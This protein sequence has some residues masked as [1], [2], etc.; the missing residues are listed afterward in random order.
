MPWLQRPLYLPLLDLLFGFGVLVADGV[1]RLGRL[2][3]DTA[4]LAGVP[5]VVLPLVL[6]TVTLVELCHCLH[7][8]KLNCTGSPV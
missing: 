5:L 7:L 3:L 1:L 2:T 8:P 6:H 4:D